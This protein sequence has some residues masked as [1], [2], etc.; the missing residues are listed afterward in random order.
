M[1]RAGLEE[2]FG[3]VGPVRNH[4]GPQP[5]FPPSRCPLSP[6]GPEGLQ[7]ESLRTNQARRAL[8]SPPPPVTVA[9]AGKLEFCNQSRSLTSKRCK[10]VVQ[11]RCFK[12]RDPKVE[13]GSG[14]AE[15]GSSTELRPTC[16][17][18]RSISQRGSSCSRDPGNEARA[19]ACAEGPPARAHLQVRCA[20][21]RPSR[22]GSSGA[23]A[24]AVQRSCSF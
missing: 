1:I 4:P 10:W 6:L 18:A 11:G 22:G 8:R 19:R 17:A 24:C 21:G 12:L 15:L 7:K 16:R 13:A 14:R 23:R 5:T 9:E 3:K 20:S 2:I